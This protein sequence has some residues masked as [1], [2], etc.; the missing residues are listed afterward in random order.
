MPPVRMVHAIVWCSPPVRTE[1]CS[2]RQYAS[3]H[4]NNNCPI[5]VKVGWSQRLADGTLD[6]GSGT[7]DI[8]P[9]AVYK[10]FAL[11][12][13]AVGVKYIACAAKAAGYATGVNNP[14]WYCSPGESGRNDTC[15]EV[16][17]TWSGLNATLVDR[18]GCVGARGVALAQ[19]H[20]RKRHRLHRRSGQRHSHE[21]LLERIRELRHKLTA[22]DAVYVAPAEVPDALLLTGD[23]PLSRPRAG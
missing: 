8:A 7:P 21:P 12:R 11:K 1:E 13:E 6:G 3:H 5:A 19:L 10:T 20:G 18:S 17:R 16:L 23:G 22:Y 9:G 14:D 4:L 2:A 15:P